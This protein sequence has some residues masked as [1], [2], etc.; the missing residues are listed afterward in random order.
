MKVNK[1]LKILKNDGWYKVKSKSSHIQLK[2]NEKSGRVTVPY[3]GK[4]LELPPKTLKSIL[5]QAKIN[6]D[7][8]I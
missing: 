5:Q 7:K 8:Q 6:L 4:D 2:H 1:V 3:H